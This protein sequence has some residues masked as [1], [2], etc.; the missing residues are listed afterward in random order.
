MLEFKPIGGDFVKL[1]K[2]LTSVVVV[3]LYCFTLHINTSMASGNKGEKLKA[4]FLMD[5]SKS[6]LKSD[7]ENIRG[8]AIKLFIDMCRGKGDSI[9]LTAYGSKIVK[10]I[11]LKGIKSFEDRDNL[12]KLIKD[13]PK[14]DST[15]IGLGLLE[16]INNLEKGTK[17]GG[18]PTIIL[19]SDGKNDPER[20]IAQSNGD[21]TK[22]IQI[23]KEKGYKIYTIGLNADGSVDVNLLKKIASETNGKSFIINAARDLPWIFGEIFADSSQLKMISKGNVQLN[24]DFQN[25]QIDIPNSNV[26]EVNISIMSQGKVELKITDNNGSIKSIP[27]DDIYCSYSNKYTLV[28]LLTPGC[29]SWT[30]GIKGQ[31]GQNADVNLIYNYELG[32]D[33]TKTPDGEYKPLDVVNVSAYLTSNGLRLEDKDFYKGLNGK[34]IVCSE[35]GDLIEEIKMNNSENG[36][37]GACKVPAEGNV[38]IMVRVDGSSFY[39]ESEKIKLKIADSTKVSEN[40]IEPLKPELKKNRTINLNGY[41]I[42]GSL[43]VL[44]A[45]TCVIVLIKRNKRRKIAAHVIDSESELTGRIMVTIKDE[46]TGQSFPPVIRNLNSYSSGISI[47]QVVPELLEYRGVEGIRIISDE[48]NLKS[49]KPER[50]QRVK[51]SITYIKIGDKKKI[52]LPGSSRVLFVE[53]MTE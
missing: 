28:K 33:V 46:L 34:I 41:L 20:S 15:D 53:Y 40:K 8:E 10:N 11:E 47:A 49:D 51:D 14:S 52:S 44:I 7:P 30:L 12:K 37:E 6:M 27:A 48:K 3:F 31:K 17:E 23:S 39:R 29:G 32:L 45:A 18:I 43:L 26:V 50:N 16:S 2:R 36:F 9:G 38:E 13:I 21:I 5:A 24:G 19:L 4:I 42:G 35:K 1:I 25:V 22:A